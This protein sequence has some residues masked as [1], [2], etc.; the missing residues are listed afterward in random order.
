MSIELFIEKI[1]QS[2]V[3]GTFVRLVFTGSPKMLGRLV[4]LKSGPHLS[5]T[6]RHGTCD[7]TRNVPLPEASRWVQ[8]QLRERHRTALLCTTEADWQLTPTGLVRH[9]PSKTTTPSREH[10]IPKRRLLD[11]SAA[12]WLEG[13]RVT[14]EAMGNKLRQIERYL[15]IV[16]HLALRCR[17][18]GSKPLTIADMGCG[19][20]YLTFAAWH[21]FHRVRGWPVHIIGIE[22]R[23]PLVESANALAARIGARGLEFVVGT[24]SSVPLP[25][26]DG[27]IALHACDTATDDAIR[28][29]IECR[30]KLIVVAPCCHKQI[31]AQL[32]HPEP[33]AAVLKH[34]IMAERL[35]E[36]L[37][38]GLRALYLEAAGYRTRVFEFIPSEHTAK[39]LMIAGIYSGR[40]GDGEAIR[41]LRT[42]FGIKSHAFE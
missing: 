41:Q 13:L 20:G 17:W 16:G 7:I 1:R 38:D 42:F 23:Q 35:A 40:R 29:G 33:F 15:E 5:I 21:L 28:R 11:N 26:L 6:F 8:E 31:R 10:D 18:D 22:S 14:R 30:A 25:R 32:A 34:G 3:N 9:K 24:I 36:W 12:D 2:F 39:N 4:E 27:L 37:T 19:K